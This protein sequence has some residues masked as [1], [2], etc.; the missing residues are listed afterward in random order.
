M[1][2]SPPGTARLVRSQG[3]FV[4][5]E[6][7]QGLVDYLKENNDP[8]VYAQA[9]QQQIDRDSR[10]DD[11]ESDSDDGEIGDDEELY[12]L[13]I[14]VLKAS[15]RA[16]TSLLQ[17]KL[18]IG[19]N[20]AARIMDLMQEKGIVGPENGSNPRDILVDLDQL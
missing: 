7:V 16:S 15:R 13:A 19:Y 6:E 14:G 8:P 20:R 12:R 1:L 2:F 18:S 9:V 4:S 11:E 17:R 10:E 5:D 3:A